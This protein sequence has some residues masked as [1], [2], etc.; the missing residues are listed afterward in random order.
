L[1]V[2]FTDSGRNRAVF[3][4]GRHLFGFFACFSLPPKGEMSPDWRAIL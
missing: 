2:V 4:G 3:D 1:L